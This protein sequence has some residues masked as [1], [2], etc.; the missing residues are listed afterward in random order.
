MISFCLVNLQ[1]IPYLLEARDK[2]VPKREL[3]QFI[4]LKIFQGAM[5]KLSKDLSQYRKVIWKDILDVGEACLKLDPKSRASTK[6]LRDMMQTGKVY[7]AYQ[8]G[9]YHG[10]ALEDVLPF[11]LGK[12][13]FFS[14]CLHE[15]CLAKI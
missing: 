5:L 7:K 14:F 9:N 1:T 12:F 3:M 4:S 13:V 8:L 2:D 15:N 6:D 11:V 10:S